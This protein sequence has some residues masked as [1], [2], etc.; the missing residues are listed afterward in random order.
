MNRT[1]IA[2]VLG[3]P[4]AEHDVSLVSGRAIAHALA[5]RG[6]DVTGWLVTLD[7]RVV[8]AAR[9][10]RSTATSRTTAYDDPLALGAEGPLTAAQRAR[11]HSGAAS[12]AR[13]VHR[14]ARS[15]RRGR[16][17][18]GAVRVGRP[19]LHRRRCC[20]LRGGHGQATLQAC[21][22][23]PRHSRRARGSRSAPRNGPPIRVPSRRASRSSAGGLSDA[24]VIVKPARLGSIVGI[25][26]VHHPDDPEYAGG[27][28]AQA[29]EYDDWCSSRPTSTIRAS[30]R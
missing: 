24:R 20:R 30:S 2:V 21:R 3:G 23:R 14:A 11:A 17:G 12:R 29:L 15:V 16:H 28:V 7:G 22:G 9:R 8:A 13:R 25:A 1:S 27:A 5:E 10:A 18:P 26:I 6:H 19:H 4:S